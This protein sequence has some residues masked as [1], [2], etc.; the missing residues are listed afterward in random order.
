M[1]GKQWVNQYIQKR[2]GSAADKSRDRQLE[3]DGL[4]K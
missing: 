4:E 2:G 1:L 3:L